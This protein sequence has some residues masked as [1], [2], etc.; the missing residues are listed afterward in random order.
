[1]ALLTSKLQT[2]RSTCCARSPHVA[3][4]YSCAS[5]FCRRDQSSSDILDLYNKMKTEYS[6]TG[7][8]EVSLGCVRDRVQSA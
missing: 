8:E 6:S 2:L 4:Y 1:M 5:V 3:F 7:E